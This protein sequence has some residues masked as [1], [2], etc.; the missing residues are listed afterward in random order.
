MPLSC[1]ITA[2]AAGTVRAVDS[3]RV[4]MVDV[5]SVLLL[6]RCQH[7]NNER[8]AP[9]F[10][11]FFAGVRGGWRGGPVPRPAASLGPP[12]LR[13]AP[14][15]GLGRQ[16]RL[17]FGSGQPDKREA[18]PHGAAE[19]EGPVARGGCSR[20]SSSLIGR[21]CLAGAS[22][23]FGLEKNVGGAHLEAPVPLRVCRQEITWPR[24]N[25]SNSPAS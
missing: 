16:P 21:A 19:Q 24:K 17:A 23:L 10:R 8:R 4:R 6:V 20:R 13:R 1:A 11:R 5:I 9:A 14:S 3:S 18:S 2:L 12:R 22:W 15:Q 7:L 25:F